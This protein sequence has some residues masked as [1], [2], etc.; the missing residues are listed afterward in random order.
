M[1]IAK[2]D[3]VDEL[4]VVEIKK[5]VWRKWR[6]GSRVAGSVCER[7]I[8]IFTSLMELTSLRTE[9]LMLPTPPLAIQNFLTYGAT[10]PS[11]PAQRTPQRL[12]LLDRILR[13]SI[14]TMHLHE[15]LYV[16][17]E[18]TNPTPRSEP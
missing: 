1:S 15:R 14:G 2:G 17:P 3:E 6:K 5:F 4:V 13:V 18:S 11:C 7:C 10:G 9:R 8:P 12:S 16:R